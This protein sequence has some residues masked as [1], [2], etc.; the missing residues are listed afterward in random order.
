MPTPAGVPVN[1]ISPALKVIPCDKSERIVG[2]SNIRFLVLEFCLTSLL[3]LQEISSSTGK[4]ISDLST[5]QGPIGQALSKLF[6]L[7]HCMCL[8]WISLAEISLA[9]VYPKI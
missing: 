3:T 5:I 9:I 4:S 8:F 6:P 1:I 7:N 2:I